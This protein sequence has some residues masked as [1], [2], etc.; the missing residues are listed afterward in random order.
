MK[1]HI[2]YRRLFVLLA[3]ITAFA[4]VC[5]GCGKSGGSA[6]PAESAPPATEA[7]DSPVTAEAPAVTDAGPSPAEISERAMQNFLDKIAAGDYVMTCE[8][9]MKAVVCSEDL[10]IFDYEEAAPYSDFAVMSL[11]NEVF[12]C[13]LTED[14]V[15]DV[16]FLREGRAIEAASLRLPNYWMEDEVSQGNIYNL[17]YNDTEDPLK[18]VSFDTAVKDQLRTLVGYGNVAINYMHEVYLTL[19]R[20]DPTL[21][22]I[23]AVVDDDVVARYY[24]DDIDITVAFGGAQSDPRVDAWLQDPAYPAARTGWTDADIFVFNSVFLPGY[25]EE[26]VPFIPSA[27]YA[28]RM[29]EDTF[30]T[31]DRIEIRDPHAVPEDVDAYIEIL[32]Q[33]GFQETVE[34][35]VIWYRRLLREDTRCYA[36]ICVEYDDGMNVTAGKYYDFPRYEGLDQINGQLAANGYPALAGTDALTDLS[37]Y[38]A[39][40]EQTESWLYFFDYRTVLY[41]TGRYADEDQLTAYLDDYADELKQQGFE[42]VFI[43]ADEESGVDYYASADGSASFR[44]HLEDDGETVILLFKAEKYLTA[45][46][47][48]AILDAAGFPGIDRSAYSSGRDHKK[49]QQVMYGKEYA[50]ALTLT[51]RFETAEE[52]EAFL[53]GYVASLEDD[54]YLRVPP[55][56]LGSNKTNGYTNEEQ[57][58]GVAFDFFPGENG[59]E[60]F[61]YFDFRSGIDFDAEADESGGGAMPILGSS[62]EDAFTSILSGS[63]PQ[64]YDG[65]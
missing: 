10:V 6:Q 5:A 41:V 47:A 43:D 45:D 65:F 11:D 59:G 14:G 42:P 16:S 17:F 55:S 3:L 13:F 57:G 30:L 18:F 44:V 37:A 52:G 22:R 9:F 50:S 38:D 27:S 26:A 21:A 29:N 25:G 40:F 51:M 19:D 60:T 39:R 33:N 7:P 1:K 24:F 31:S 53:D 28:M 12:Q 8:G 20:E 23:Q 56:D 2:G 34:D 61:I 32:R 63:A 58:T 4:V 54:G 15:R 64:A 36:S 62:H 35:G 48:A 49:F 46:E